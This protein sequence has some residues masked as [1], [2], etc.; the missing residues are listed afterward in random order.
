MKT[1]QANG[2]GVSVPQVVITTL[3]GRRLLLTSATSCSVIPGFRALVSAPFEG[4]FVVIAARHG[5]NAEQRIH[6]LH[7]FLH[8]RQR[9]KGEAA[10]NKRSSKGNTN[11]TGVSEA[12]LS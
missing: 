11:N 10:P 1:L 7:M 12:L 3:S 4:V 9:A 5:G 8:I 2:F 6:G